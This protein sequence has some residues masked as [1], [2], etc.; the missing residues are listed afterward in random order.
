MVK[1]FLF[2]HIEIYRKIIRFLLVGSMSTGIDFCIYII[3][4]NVTNLIFSKFV[5]TTIACII[6][7]V[8]NKNWT[9]K[10]KEGMN[11]MLIFKY[12]I[13]Q[14]CNITC[15]VAINTVVY[16]LTQERFIAFIAATLC[17][18]TLNFL[19]QKCYVFRT[20]VY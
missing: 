1:K 11:F 6:S 3:L 7:L 4:S 13:S 19:L 17:A 8:V 20:K 9:F 2:K 18:M 15:N 14:I 5:S 10:Y 16:N 12:S